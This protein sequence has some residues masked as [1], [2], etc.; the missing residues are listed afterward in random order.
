[1]IP[2]AEA[3]LG[4]P[5]ALY[6]FG[7]EWWQAFPIAIAGNMILV[8]F[9]L[10]FF[11]YAEQY[12][13]KFKTSDRL[14]DRV[15]SRIRNRT[16]KKIQRYKGLALIFFVALPLPFTGAGIGVLIAYLFDFK[17]KDSLIMIFTGVIIA[18]TAITI[19]YMLGV[20]LFEL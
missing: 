15:F 14:M 12:F 17:F 16:N 1:M 20:F 10:K 13:R 5:Y 11:K 8:P 9:G 3:K 6:N 7:W 2:G 19:L 18:T 4:V